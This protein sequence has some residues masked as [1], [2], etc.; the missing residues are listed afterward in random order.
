MALLDQQLPPPKRPAKELAALFARLQMENGAVTLTDLGKAQNAPIT[1]RFR[2]V[3]LGF[4][5]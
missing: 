3:G 2:R 5:S 4:G 1:G